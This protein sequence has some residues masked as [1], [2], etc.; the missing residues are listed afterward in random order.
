VIWFAFGSVIGSFL[1]VCIYRLPR[2]QSIVT[3][4]S[5]CPSCSTPI[6]WYD[7]V[8][9]VSFLALGARCR[10]CRGRIAWR[11]PIVELLTALATVAVLDRFGMTAVGFVYLAFVYGLIV[12][13]FVDLDFQI[14][15]DEIS[16]GGLAL[17]LAAS[18]A[19]PQLHGTDQRLLALRRSVV[20]AAVGGGLLYATGALGNVMLYG[21]RRLG[22]RMRRHP[23][24]RA[25]LSKYRHMR[26][27]MG[28]GDVK[29]LAMAGS[30]LGWQL[31]VFTFFVA[32][33]LAVIPG[34]VVLALH[35][36]HIIPYGP[37]LALGLLLALFAGH[38]IIEASAI[39]ETI[40]ALWGYYTAGAS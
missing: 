7:N 26:E 31:V 22:I 29:L 40:R 14:I 28:F 32:P 34:L 18:L 27:A 24:W 8:P 37:F 5:R 2:E 10:H 25:R 6:A 19:I 20:G 35:R 17:G 11:Y 16:L 13:S 33:V 1:N 39:G 15:P 3:P 23:R 38:R 30:L 21:L 9:L 4:R 36:S 12:A